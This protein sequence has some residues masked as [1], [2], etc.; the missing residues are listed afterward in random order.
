MEIS[1]NYQMTKEEY[2]EGYDE[3]LKT[4]W[5]YWIDM[6]ISVLILIYGIYLLFLGTPIFIF[7]LVIIIISLATFIKQFRISRLII[8]NQFSRSLKA[9]TQQYIEFKENGLTYKIENVIS[10]IKWDYYGRVLFTKNTIVLIYDKRG[11]SVIP[12]RAFKEN[13]YQIIKEFLENRIK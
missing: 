3:Y 4:T 7:G 2:L 11:F 13:D 8:G 6:F 10:E 5:H 9:K 12:I 1:I